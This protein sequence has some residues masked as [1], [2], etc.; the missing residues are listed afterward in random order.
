MRPG[1]WACGKKKKLFP[2]I[3]IPEDW[4][5]VI[6]AARKNPFKLNCMGT[7]DF[8]STKKLEN[9]I[10]NRKIDVDKSKVQWLKI[11]WLRFSSETP[12]KIFYKY[13]NNEITHFSELD[14][15]KR[16]TTLIE[17]LDL[18]FPNGNC[19]NVL[20]KKDLMSLLDYVPPIHHAYYNSLKTNAQ[21]VVDEVPLVDFSSDEEA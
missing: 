1:L 7:K 10:T 15:E 3:F 5:N 9:N 18:L 6:L 2:N 4:N 8:F 13:S 16:N 20:K 17:N 14:V 19:I 21:I 12:F 11:Q